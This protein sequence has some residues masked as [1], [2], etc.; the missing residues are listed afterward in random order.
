MYAYEESRK[1]LNPRLFKHKYSF[2]KHLLSQEWSVSIF[3]SKIKERRGYLEIFLGIQMRRNWKSYR[4]E[5]S[6]SRSM[7][8]MEI[9]FFFSVYELR[10]FAFFNTLSERFNRCILEKAS[11]TKD[12]FKGYADLLRMFN[13]SIEPAHWRSNLPNKYAKRVPQVYF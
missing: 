7:W 13:W 6:V 1:T 9:C 11:R 8:L 12:V 2:G 5:S 4:Y 10:R 3:S